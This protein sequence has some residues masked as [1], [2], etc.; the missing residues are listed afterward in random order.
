MA[1]TVGATKSN[2]GNQASSA[3]FNFNHTT[4]ANTKCL[5]VVVTGVDSSATDS[6]VSQ[7]TW[8]GVNLAEIAGGRFR[9]GSDFISIWYKSLPAIAGPT[10]CAVTM[11]GTCTDVQ[12][13]ALNLVDASAGSI[14]YDSF[15]TG[16][17]TG[18]ATSTVSPAKTN[19][20][21][22]GGGV[23]DGGTPASLSITTGTES[24]GS[25]VDMGSQCAS[26]GYASESGG[27]ATIVWTY[28]AVVCSSLAATFYSQFAPTVALNTPADTGKTPDT[29]PGL[30]FT[31]TDANG[32][33]LEYNIN[34]SNVNDFTTVQTQDT[35]DDTKSNN[36]GLISPTTGAGQT[37]TADFGAL[38]GKVGFYIGKVGTPTAENI[39]VEIY[40]ITGT[41][42]T[43]SK[44]T[45]SAIATSDRIATVDIPAGPG[46]VDFT[47]SGANRI[48]LIAGHQYAAMLREL[49]GAVSNCIT[50]YY[51]SS[52]PTHDGNYFTWNGSTYTTDSTLDFNF[53]VYSYFISLDKASDTPSIP[54]FSGTGDPHPWPSGNAVTYTVQAAD[55]LVNKVTYYWR[56]RA[57]DP[58]GLNAYSSF[59]STYSFTVNTGSTAIVPASTNQAVKRASTY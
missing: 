55:E 26:V 19:S 8:N 22:V 47:F 15:D 11:G 2:S 7:I 43:N 14:V 39:V 41:Y 38:L 23:A 12:A 3:A 37:W 32:D 10:A 57:K 4:D 6:V 21:A 20:I 24:T 53:R 54:G 42:G 49:S 17:G 9:V 36:V 50:I 31:G 58:L 1:I 40:E 29:T 35:Y 25:E 5:V 59:S 52:S 27:T 28:A 33:E 48:S 56:V 34:I 13:T 51:D 16:T 30:V 45:G 46:Y 44:P 18:S